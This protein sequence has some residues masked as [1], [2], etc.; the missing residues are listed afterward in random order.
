[1]VRL[2]HRVFTDLAIWMIGLGLLMGI[3]FPF[4]LL[5][6]GIPQELVI[7]PWFFVACMAAGFIVGSVNIWLARTVV[8]KRLRFLVNRMKM[9]EASLRE[10][11]RTGNLEQCSPESCM[12]IVDSEDEL[13]E[14]SKAFNYL[15]DALAKSHH[16]YAAIRSFSGML[17]SQ[18][19]LDSLTN[20]ALQHLLQHTN[21]N[22]GALLIA[23]DGEMKIA[24]SYGIRA[25]ESL[26]N[27]D[28]V[29]RVLRT[30]NKLKVSIPDDVSV[31]GVLTD[32]RPS[33][34]L[35]MPLSY[36]GIPLGVLILASA[37]R[38]KN[39]VIFSLDLLCQNMA[40]SLHNALTYDHLQKM[41]ALD[42]LTGIYNRRFGM[43]RLSEEFSRS[44]RSSTPL[45]LI[46]LD[47][48]FFKKVNDCYGHLAGDRVLIQVIKTV[49]KSIRKGDIFMR[50]GGEEFLIILP[51]AS[52]EDSRAVSEKMRRMVE[53]TSVTEG[54]Q[55]IRV[56]VSIGV[57]S[58]PELDVDN[59]HDFV[60]HVDEALYQAKE[61]GRNK[62]CVSR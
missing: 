40:I 42:P 9:V 8:G 18:L 7:T 4:F 56:T 37:V 46:M 57:T 49:E 10:I 11:S 26:K 60:K 25:P 24:A 5:I 3:V 29:H 30:E 19:E 45:G 23:T 36:K 15:I 58:Y 33:E 61:T 55:I 39:E 12:M 41:V 54:D 13:G 59:E 50:Y 28:Y 53:D 14:T 20:Q 21:A 52:K 31:D 43:T 1:M 35:V 47:I 38:F 2:T 27:S 16:S 17:A 48:D 34:V 22:A 44:I 32:F 6:M 51:G 62:V